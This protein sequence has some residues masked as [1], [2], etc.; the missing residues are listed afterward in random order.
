MKQLNEVYRQRWKKQ[1]FELENSGLRAF[2][3]AEGRRIPRRDPMGV[4]FRIFEFFL[5]LTPF[6]AWGKSNAQKIVLTENQI[7]S[8]HVAEASLKI[9]HLSDLHINESLIDLETLLWRIKEVESYHLVCITGDLATGWPLEDAVREKLVKFIGALSPKIEVLVVLG[10][11]DSGHLVEFLEGLGATV[12]TNQIKRYEKG[13]DIP[14]TFEVIGTDD[15]HYFFQRDAVRIFEEGQKEVF[16]LALVHSPELFQTAANKGC[17]LYLCGHTHGGQIALP[18]GKPIV[19][20]VYRGKRFA[21]GKWS[22]QDMQGYTSTGVGT[23][24][25][26]VRFNTTG[27]IAV[28]QLVPKK[29]S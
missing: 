9:L 26:P 8:A 20:R 7:P 11:H 15:P 13:P 10:N 28:H 24:S 27:E 29:K 19:K 6:F 4:L 5:R 3:M 23:S 1:R 18:G 17:D 2:P 14:L 16:R 22:Y 25:V 21:A 12:L